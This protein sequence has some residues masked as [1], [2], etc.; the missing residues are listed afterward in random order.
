MGLLLAFGVALLE[1]VKDAVGKV[2]TRRTS[3]L[4]LLS[5]YKG[6]AFLLVLPF[7]LLRDATVDIGTFLPVAVL[8]ASLNALAFY[9][10]LRAISL[11][12]LSTTV[13]MLSFSPVFL[14]IT[15]RIMLGQRVPPMGAVGVV[16][17]AVGSYI[18][19]LKDAR[20]GWLSP[21]AALFREPGPKY[22]LF[23][24]L[25]WSITANL[26]RIG[27]GASDPLLWVAAMDAGVL[28]TTLPFALKGRRKGGTGYLH[29]LIMGV[30]DALGAVLQMV[31][32]TLTLVPYVIA[33]KRTSVVLSSA[34]GILL[35]GE[36]RW[37]ERL[38]GSAVMLLG[39]VMILL[40]LFG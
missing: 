6:I 31:A 23:V 17:V 38:A 8:N 24:S 34:L 2:A 5:L 40:T 22:M 11:S 18:L 19:N 13:P 27:V 15:S 10:Y 4:R 9:L 14:L 26:D 28:L 39:A 29:P 20:R 30:A 21:I 36:E 35:F 1:S 3:P 37:R 16:L 32:I 25:I 7:A 33:V 12:P